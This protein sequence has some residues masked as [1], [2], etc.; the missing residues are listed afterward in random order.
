MA[1][2]TG[3]AAVAAVAG[4]AGTAQANKGGG[5]SPPHSSITRIGTYT[6]FLTGISYDCNFVVNNGNP[7]GVYEWDPTPQ[8]PDT[9][10]LPP[11]SACY[12]KFG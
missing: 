4:T 1:L 11:S 10:I 6:S 9:E 8:F 3:V 12:L 2:T 5:G 7:S